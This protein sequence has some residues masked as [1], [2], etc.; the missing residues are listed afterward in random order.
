MSVK[1]FFKI[2]K[3]RHGEDREKANKEIMDKINDGWLIKQM[4]HIPSTIE[5]HN[6]VFAASIAVLFEKEENR[7]NYG[8][9]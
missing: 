9:D 7:E 4:E 8:R 1:Q 6:V 5:G 2:W 3:L